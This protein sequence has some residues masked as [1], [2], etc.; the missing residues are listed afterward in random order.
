[1]APRLLVDVHAAL[2][3]PGERVRIRAR[4]RATELSASNRTLAI[5]AAAATVAL[6]GVRSSSP[7]RLW[8]TA[9][10]G[11]YEGEWTASDAGDIDVTVTIGRLTADATFAVAPD[12]THATS[13]DPEGL[14]LA[15]RATG[16]EVRPLHEADA[17]AAS[18]ASR[19]PAR[20]VRVI[21]HPM[22]SPWWS[23]LFTSVLGAE[24]TWRRRRGLR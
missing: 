1:M 16:G 12:V 24:W 6:R 11:A 7:V 14:A 3:R 15:A 21:T 13:D 22:R 18:L 2:V 9:E 5:P 23:L 4:L 19:R 20:P 8:P 17:L 10:P